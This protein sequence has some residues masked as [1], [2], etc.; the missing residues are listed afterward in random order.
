MKT[1]QKFE[2]S[3]SV[4]IILI[5][6]VFLWETLGLP[7]GTFEPLGSGPVPQ[8]T[9]GVIII[10]C[11][12]VITGAWKKRDAG[13]VGPSDGTRPTIPAA[14]L[15]VVAT[16]VFVVTLQFRLL[17]FS[18]MAAIFLTFTIWGLEKF[19]TKK[20]LPALITGLIVGFAM[21]YL[22]TKVFFVDLPT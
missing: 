15:M 6:L 19:Q 10:L 5:C 8:A 14:I 20:L 16:V 1:L 9:A 12:M 3:V 17:P 4:L 13:K 21:E 18:W 7:P 2:I 22:F 11:L